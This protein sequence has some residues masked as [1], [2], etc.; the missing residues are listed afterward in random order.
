MAKLAFH[1][2]GHW[3][4]RRSWRSA[5]IMWEA[6][7]S[8][9]E[10]VSLSPLFW[11][12]TWLTWMAKLAFHFWGH[13][14][15]RRTWRSP[16]IMW[17]A[18]NSYVQLVLLSPSFW[19][20][21]WLICIA[22]TWSSYSRSLVTSEDFEVSWHY[23][24]GWKCLV[25]I[26]FIKGSLQNKKMVKFGKKSKR[27]GGGSDPIPNFLNRFKKCLECSETHNKH[28]KYFFHF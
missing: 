6:K 4:P 12:Q 20:Q 24:G 5:M 15:P 7:N 23:L 28:I 21:T 16:V 1:F 10:L 3:W 9:N 26:S 8:F 11:Y 22:K 25:S 27:G 17:E 14:W 13:W 19:Y 2:W 18:K